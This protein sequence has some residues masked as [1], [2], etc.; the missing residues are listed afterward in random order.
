MTTSTIFLNALRALFNEVFIKV[1][2]SY[3]IEETFEAFKIIAKLLVSCSHEFIIND[4]GLWM[5]EAKFAN[6]LG[7]FEGVIILRQSTL[8]LHVQNSWNCLYLGT[9][10][11]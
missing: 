1:F 3:L 7:V 6:Q 2:P 4:I 5:E 8:Y 9:L 10:V 11:H